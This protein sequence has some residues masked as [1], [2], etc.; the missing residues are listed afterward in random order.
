MSSG[1]REPVSTAL[2][3]FVRGAQPFVEAEFRKVYGDEKWMEAALTTLRSSRD[4]PQQTGNAIRWDAQSIVLLIHEQWPGVFRFKL[5]S[6][7]R[8]MLS[9]LREFRN[10][11][12]HQGAFDF[13]DAL[14]VMDTVR[15]L[16][17]VMESTEAAA[18]LALRDELL[19]KHVRGMTRTEARQTV[20][21]LNR[22]SWVALFVLCGVSIIWQSWNTF[23]NRAWLFNVMV[24]ATFGYLSWQRLRRKP[25]TG[26]HEC[27]DCG[28]I[29]Y[30]TP[31]PYCERD[32]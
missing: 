17:V 30:G 22:W 21:R 11:W 18:A 15:R 9:E 4:V 24:L 13:D 23:G 2:D 10:R 16:L 25:I 27:R 5:S 12:A 19:R 31:C 32:G 6:L 3:M 29:I 20:S 14:R 7:E 8:P 26:V 28:R 1:F